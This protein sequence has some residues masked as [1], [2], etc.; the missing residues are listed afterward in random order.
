MKTIKYFFIVVSF[1]FS[2][3]TFSQNVPEILYYKFNTG[4]TT[5]PNLAVPGQGTPDAVLVGQTMGPGGQFG[6]ALMGNGGT[7]STAYV[8]SGWN[9]NIGTSNWTI[10][11]W[12][13]YSGTPATTYLFG[14]DITT[15]FRCFTQGAAGTGNI[16]LR[17]NGI[18]NVDVTGVIPGGNVV[19]FVY[20]SSIPAI[21]TYVNGVFQS[22]ITQAAPLNLTAA[23]PF[24]V[25]GYGTAN[26]IPAGTLLDEFRFYSRAL[27]QSE[28]T[29]T[30]NTE[31]P[32][33]SAI[34]NPTKVCDYGLIP[35]FSA[36]VIGGNASATLGDT[37]YIAG[38]SVNAGTVT[39]P[40]ASTTVVRYAINSGNWSAGRNL[41]T[42]KVGGDLVKCGNALYYMGGGS[43][44][45]TG[46][47][48]N[49]IYK[50][51]P[52]A[53]W[54]SC[55]NIPTPVTGNVAESWGDSVVFCIMGGWSTYYRGIQIY[56]PASNTWD[57]ASD[58]LPATF[59]RR[60]FA[61]GISGNKILVAS[62]YSGSFRKDF[63]IGTIGAN[64]NTISWVQKA[65]MPMRGT[66]SRP[67]GH[68]VNG[69][70]YVVLGETTP[71]QVA[72][73][74]I[75]VYNIAD[76]SWLPVPL[77][78][79]GA[80]SASNYWGLISS[81]IINN[82]VKIWIP[83]GFYPT[84]VTTSKLICLTDSLG[85]ITTG[86][87]SQNAIVPEAYNLSQNYPNPFNPATRIVYAIPKQGLIKMKVYDILGK[88]VLTLVNEFKNAGEYYIDF[89]GR[90]LSSGIYFYKLEAGDF[91]STKKMILVK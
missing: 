89:D 80:N 19:H 50:Y 41:P 27:S 67:G 26:S 20:D 4:T 91:I 42:A 11:L 84:T 23:V 36:G 24:K 54:T 74:S 71:G 62:G 7:G 69:R 70:F 12:F 10:S 1:F 60:T 39:N 49:L 88:E 77:T 72:Q 51:D 6:N 18:T 5:T 64:A 30:W 61:G 35:P 38:G 75:Q 14:N 79:R 33:S 9:M 87:G 78:G 44:T 59:G 83:G 66:N 52:A 29:A 73:D 82:K 28:I 63:W 85:C 13:N 16:T 25:G 76:S 3:N 32:V 65:D 81:S 47:A 48:D 34:V 46:A 43:A 31:L 21:K 56:R 15:S 2:V 17:G 45:L 58:S 55:A 22:S 90:N 57:R 86:T 8:N 40:A 68:A 37:L 53:G